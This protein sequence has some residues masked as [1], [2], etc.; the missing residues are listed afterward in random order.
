MKY[1]NTKIHTIKTINCMNIGNV[2]VSDR[3]GSLC[4]LIVIDEGQSNTLGI[5]HID[6]IPYEAVFNYYLYINI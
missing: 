1:N 6:I 2:P 4:V 3:A 5:C